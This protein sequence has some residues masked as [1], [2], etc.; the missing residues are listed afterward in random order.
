MINVF[1]CSGV[2]VFPPQDFVTSAPTLLPLWLDF[3]T[4]EDPEN[5]QRTQRRNRKYKIVN[6]KRMN[7]KANV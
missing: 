3:L 7:T 6:C 4:A 1:R 2:H 5:A